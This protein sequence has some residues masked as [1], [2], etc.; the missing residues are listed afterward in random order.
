MIR[1]HKPRGRSGG[2]KA[3]D[4]FSP[5]P[6]T[7]RLNAVLN[8]PGWLC[9]HRHRERRSKQLD[10]A[11]PRLYRGARTNP[12]VATGSTSPTVRMTLVT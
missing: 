4:A 1:L 9:L 7:N 12:V 6:S 2:E 8:R 5:S 10:H 3:Y 11:I